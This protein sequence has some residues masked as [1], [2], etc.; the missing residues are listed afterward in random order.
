[1]TPLRIEHVCQHSPEQISQILQTS[2]IIIILISLHYKRQCLSELLCENRWLNWSQN[3]LVECLTKCW[4]EYSFNKWQ[5]EAP[6]KD[7]GTRLA[8]E[9]QSDRGESDFVVHSFYSVTLLLLFFFLSYP[10]SQTFPVK[11]SAL[12]TVL[13]PDKPFCITKLKFI[14]L[15]NINSTSSLGVKCTDVEVTQVTAE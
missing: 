15:Q 10:F 13:W 7:T 4:N 12:H 5:L 3:L 2:F 8:A 6:C 1:M 14:H 11:D 9:L